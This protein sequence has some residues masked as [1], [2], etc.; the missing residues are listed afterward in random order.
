MTFPER[1]PYA[2]HSVLPDDKVM[3][4]QQNGKKANL[5]G[6]VVILWSGAAFSLGKMS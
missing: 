2:V 5:R 6:V 4:A 3:V 1:V